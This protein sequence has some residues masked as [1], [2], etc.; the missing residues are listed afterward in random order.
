LAERSQQAAN[1]INKLSGKG[2]DISSLAEKELSLLI[3]DVETTTSMIKEVA[4]AS[5]EQS[6]NI[7]QIQNAVKTLNNIAQK[8]A[9]SSVG[10]D[11]STK[12]LN[13]EA[14][15][16]KTIISFFKI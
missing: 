15:H 5:K 3:P 1:H 16:L 4:S 11:D 14:E 10:L 2:I 8:N 7:E 6:S 12:N 9:H 13:K